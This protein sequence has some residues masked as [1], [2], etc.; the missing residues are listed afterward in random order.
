MQAQMQAHQ[1]AQQAQMQAAATEEVIR[2]G[3]LDLMKIEGERHS[4]MHNFKH[5][6]MDKVATYN[7][8]YQL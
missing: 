4:G 5:K 2:R 7:K 8:L 6:T 3:M 1:Q